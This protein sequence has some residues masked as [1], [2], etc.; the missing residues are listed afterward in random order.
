MPLPNVEN[1]TA[2]RCRAR[3][4]G[5]NLAPC[6]NLAAYGTPVCTKHGAVHPNKR[7]KGKTHGRFKHGNDTTEAVTKRKEFNAVLLHIEDMLH[8]VG[9]IEG[10]QHTSGKRPAGFEKIHTLDQAKKYI[11]ELEANK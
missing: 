5:R 3:T 4:K 1:G 6:L 9:A 11:L 10:Q 8:L 7:P 2:N